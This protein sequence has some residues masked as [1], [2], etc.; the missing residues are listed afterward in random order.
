MGSILKDIQSK[1]NNK[2]SNP[3]RIENIEKGRVDFRT[4]CNLINPSFYKPHRAYQD[5]L[6]GTLQNFWENKLVNEATGKPYKILIINL[7]PGFGKSYTVGLFC[8]WIFGQDILNKVICVS[9]N[10]DIAETFSTTVRDTIEDE[11]FFGD[12]ESYVVNTFFPKVKIKHGMGAKKKWALEGN[13]LSYISA[14]F[15]GT[16]TGMRGILG[17]IDDPIKK[18]EEALNDRV[19]EQHHNFYKNTF[20]SRMESG[21]KR[22]I[23]QTRWASD[24]LA[25]R[26]IGDEPDDTYVLK[27]NALDENGKSLCE[28]LYSTDDLLA[29]N[30][31]IDDHIFL[32]N[33]MNVCIDLKGSLYPSFNC[34]SYLPLDIESTYAYID[35]ADEGSDFLCAICGDVKDSIGY[36]K[37][38]LYTDE[39]MEVTEEQTALFLMRNEVRIALFES[40]NGGRGFARAVEKILH[41]KYKYKKCKITWFHQ[42][43]PKVTRINVNSSNVINQLMFPENLSKNYSKYSIDMK[44][45]QRKGKNEHDDAPDATTGLVEMIN[46]DVK[47]KTSKWGLKRG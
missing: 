25:G 7:P 41:E 8:T 21:A 27:L 29:K 31:T 12:D 38:I 4:Y 37:D 43:K 33:F 10:G 23:I 2:I 17:I 45:Y 9:Y 20:L 40:N 32:A 19:K 26:V 6:C 24:D 5:V 36:V 30:K 13:Y 16:L 46:G 1:N 14:G 44:K 11:E 28:D 18:A 3:K 15:D 34:Y 35:T 22:I 42:S 47:A 39:P